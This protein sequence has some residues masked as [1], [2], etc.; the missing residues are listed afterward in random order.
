MRPSSWSASRVP[1][2]AN[3]AEK[4]AFGCTKRTSAKAGQVPNGILGVLRVCN[5]A[6]Q[7]FNI[8]TG[9]DAKDHKEL[10]ERRAVIHERSASAA[11]RKRA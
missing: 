6:G 7:E 8:G 9:L 10:W 11:I 2:N 3:E 5:T 4:E 1:H